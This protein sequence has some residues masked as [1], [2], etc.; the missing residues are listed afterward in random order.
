MKFNDEKIAILG[1][2]YV[3][4]PVAV[5]IA[6]K[7]QNVTG[8]DTSSRRV[9]S[10]NSGEDWTGEVCGDVLSLSDIIISD[11]PDALGD[12]SFFI[13]TVPT[14]IDE[15]N[16]PDLSPLESACEL[17][18]PHL[19]HGAIVVFESTVYPGATDDFCAPLLEKHSGLVRGRDFFLGY[20]P[21]RINPGDK[22]HR[23]ETI[24]KIIS[25]ENPEALKRVARVYGA[26]V[27]VG[28]HI[29]PSIK[30]A[31]AAKVI[32]NTQRDLNIALM[33][34][35]SMIMDKM[36]IRTS[37]VLKAA[38]T[39][40]NFLPF[41]PGLV[42]GHCIGVDPYYLTSAAEKKGYL[43]E[44]ILAGRRINDAMGAHVARKA[45]KLLAKSGREIQNAKVGILGLTFKE[46]VPDFRNSKVP[47][48]IA[49]LAEYG[50]EPLIHDPFGNGG[51][52]AAD[53]ALSLSPLETFVDLDLLILAV[54]HRNYL[55]EG[56]K[57]AGRIQ[58][59]GI[60]MDLKSMIRV[61]DVPSDITIWSL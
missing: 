10:L 60:L 6:Q 25:A 19:S 35:V 16:R 39:K 55:E 2:G 46:D 45:I 20:S 56:A 42:G 33:N 59:G 23:L 47:D 30:V 28:L 49:E 61:E 43:P 34:E 22:E 4:L 21:E 53:Y 9:A 57:L 27:D 12:T 18:G 29:A 8:F 36:E 38:N 51:D 37:D 3:G 44:V 5:A 58:S 24:T 32:E 50:I 52:A 13:V 1:L 14:P 17:I 31:E 15:D 26:I 41:T 48:I 7:F 40:W 11:C 54:N